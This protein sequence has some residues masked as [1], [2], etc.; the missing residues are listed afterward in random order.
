MPSWVFKELKGNMELDTIIQGDCLEVMRGMDEECVDLVVTDPPYGL[1]FM[2]KSWDKALPSVDIWRECLRVLKPGAFAFVMCIPRQDCL[3]RMIINLED[4]GFMVNFSPIYHTFATGFPKAANLSK[5]ADR[6]AGVEREVVGTSKGKGGENLNVLSRIE[7]ND[8][9]E[10]KGCGAYGQGAKQ[11]TIDVPIT[12]SATPE[13][14][15]LD[16]A[17]AGLQLKPAVEVVLCVMKPCT[18]KTYLDQALANGKGCT[19]L[20]NGRI[21]YESD[22][23]IDSRVGNEI[24]YGNREE[25]VFDQIRYKKICGTAQGRF[26]PNLLCSDDV[27]N[28]GRVRKS[29]GGNTMRGK[30]DK[31]GDWGHGDFHMQGYGDSGSYSRYFSLDQWADKN[32][33]DSVNRTFPFMI[34]PKASKSEKNAGLDELPDKEMYHKDGRGN[35]LECF[36]VD[37]HRIPPGPRKNHHPTVKPIKLMSYLIAIGSRSG[38]IVLDPYVGSGTTAIAA[39]ISNRQYIGIELDPDMCD[40]AERRIEWHVDERIAAEQVQL[41]LF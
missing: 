3:S 14:K 33:P 12:L 18:E 6:R 10:A 15:A 8:S 22:G 34:V 21:P 19:W 13:A 11:I 29:T 17:Y 16:G 2:G 30:V 7:G 23:D 5:L 40:I 32:L 24:S 1:S 27:L 38:D 9:P 37:E 4:A 25:R 20:D 36:G 31:I 28:D 26:A 35:A 39:A 41:R